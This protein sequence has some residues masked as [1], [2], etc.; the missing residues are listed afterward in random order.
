MQKISGNKLICH[1][2]TGTVN[3]KG[4]G[5]TMKMS[6]K[7]ILYLILMQHLKHLIIAAIAVKGRIVEKSYGVEPLFQS[8][9]YR[10]FEPT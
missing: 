6:V 5:F 4:M 9:L 7:A 1:S 10:H 8:C 3:S 2:V